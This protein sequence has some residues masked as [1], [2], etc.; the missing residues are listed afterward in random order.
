MHLIVIIKT[1]HNMATIAQPYI[2][3]NGIC[4]FDVTGLKADILFFINRW[5][6]YMLMQ[7]LPEKHTYFR[8]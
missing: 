6:E 7:N 3:S 5:N 8:K 2:T 4:R 1:K